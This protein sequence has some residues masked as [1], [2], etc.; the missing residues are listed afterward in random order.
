MKSN[1]TFFSLFLVS[2]LGFSIATQAQTI[3]ERTNPGIV[4]ESSKPEKYNLYKDM[5]LSRDQQKKLVLLGRDSKTQIKA[6]NEDSTLSRQEKRQKLLSIRSE[7]T[8]KRR[9]ILSA[10]QLEQ[11]EKN[12]A[13]IR[14]KKANKINENDVSKTITNN[15]NTGK[16]GTDENGLSR[17]SNSKMSKGKWNDLD[18]TQ[19]QKKKL[20]DLTFETREKER[21]ILSNLAISKEERKSQLEQLRYEQNMA[22]DEILTPAQKTAWL[23][24]QRDNKLMRTGK[25]DNRNQLPGSINR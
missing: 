1:N 21:N 6:V 20:Q 11:Y 3:P 16:N 22:L 13:E 17:K 24:K 2:S 5:N 8:D 15:T 19:E 25:M 10:K 23:Q 9:S 14:Q 7:V 12:L 4:T 18:L